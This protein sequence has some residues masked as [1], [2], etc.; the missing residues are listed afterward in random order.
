LWQL[1]VTAFPTGCHD[2]NAHRLLDTLGVG[3]LFPLH[4]ICVSGISVEAGKGLFDRFALF[5]LFSGQI[6]QPPLCLVRCWSV[7]V[8]VGFTGIVLARRRLKIEAIRV[9]EQQQ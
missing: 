8:I 9:R 6:H 5:P 7:V 2:L 4:K 3:G 1:V